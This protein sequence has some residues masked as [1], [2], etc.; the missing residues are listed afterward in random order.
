MANFIKNT[1]IIRERVDNV[2]YAREMGADPSTRK[3][4]G[5]HHD[6]RTRTGQP[7]IHQLKEDQL[8]AD[9]RRAAE[10]N[11]TLQEA[12]ERAKVIYYL[13]KNG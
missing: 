8:W 11:P 1:P 4:I 10:T 13:S 5:Q 9:L 6:P 3:E 2:I 7:L 12:L